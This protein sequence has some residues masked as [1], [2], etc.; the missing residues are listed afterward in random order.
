MNT[1]NFTLFFVLTGLPVLMTIRSFAQPHKKANYKESTCIES[2]YVD[3]LVSANRI[4]KNPG[5]F[6]LPK[7]SQQ[8]FDKLTERQLFVY[9]LN[10]PESF[11]QICSAFIDSGYGFVSRD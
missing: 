11:Y 5:T 6:E 7:L 8:Q 1:K 2:T 4:H 9:A 10:Y 3:S